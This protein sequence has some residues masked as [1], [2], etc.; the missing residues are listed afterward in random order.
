MMTEKYHSCT[1]LKLRDAK[2]AKKSPRCEERS[3][4]VKLECDGRSSHFA[5]DSC[6][7]RILASRPSFGLHLVAS[8]FAF[9]SF[10]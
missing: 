6:A 7:L 1:R 3:S 5:S 10:A 2:D 4:D 8:L 9:C